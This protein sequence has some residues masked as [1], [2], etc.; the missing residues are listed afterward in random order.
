MILG[1][2]LSLTCPAHH[3][4]VLWGV[5]L[6]GPLGIMVD[7]PA[8]CNNAGATCCLLSVSFQN[9]VQKSSLLQIHDTHHLIDLCLLFLNSLF[10]HLA[11]PTNVSSY[12]SHF[13]PGQHTSSF[14]GGGENVKAKPM[15]Q[16][17]T[18]ISNVVNSHV[19]Y[20]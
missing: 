3:L 5:S 18:L 1:A 9:L 20:Q 13:L 2:V 17:N 16:P 10:T 15:K 4:C 11:C 8:I 7:L 6:Q 19:I 14:L 12:M